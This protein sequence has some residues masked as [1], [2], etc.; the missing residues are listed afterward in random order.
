MFR[1]AK[2][3]IPN[4]QDYFRYTFLAGIWE[5]EIGM[6]RCNFTP[7]VKHC[8]YI[9]TE[10]RKTKDKRKSIL[11]FTHC[12]ED[13]RVILSAPWGE[14]GKLRA[15]EAIV[16]NNGTKIEWNGWRGTQTWFKVSGTDIGNNIVFD[17]V[18]RD[19]N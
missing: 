18:G 14:K 11:T 12:N 3:A 6:K 10:D 17:P 13:D 9:V 7:S 2:P 19:T 4:A 5:D 8:G 1:K 15:W 16:K